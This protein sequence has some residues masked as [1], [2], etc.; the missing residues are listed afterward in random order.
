MIEQNRHSEGKLHT[1]GFTLVEL[2]VVIAIIGVLVALLLPAVQAAR[3]AARRSQCMNNQRQI[4]IAVQNY[5]SATKYLPPVRVADGQQTWL[6][7]LLPY[8]EQANI[9]QLW[10]PQLGSFYEQRYAMRTAVVEAFICPSQFH[11]SDIL[12]SEKLPGTIFSHPATDTAPEAAGSGWQGS[13]SDYRAVGGSTCPLLDI[14]GRSTPLKID[15]FNEK[16]AKYLDGPI[17]AAQSV[18]YGGADGRGALSFKAFTSFKHITDG[19]SLT[20]IGGEVGLGIS[21]TSH[22]FSGDHSPWVF[23]GELRTFCE[24]CTTP[25]DFD[26]PSLGG[27]IGFGGG[28]PGIVNFVFC[29]GHVQAISYETDPRVF[30]QMATRAGGELYDLDGSA[31]TCQNTSGPVF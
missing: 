26:N 14:P 23:M 24:R 4:G 22:A 3:E 30:D 1:H 12:I 31:P 18:K 28:H 13:I 29:D 19:T 15:E 9:E 5:H 6:A 17:P 11:E 21:E 16:W 25:P 8:M 2:L 10:D 27:D 20:P 7:L